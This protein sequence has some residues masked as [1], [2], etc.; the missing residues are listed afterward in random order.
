MYVDQNIE[1]VVEQ[2]G[3]S[4]IFGDKSKDDFE[5]SKHT[6]KILELTEESL[7]DASYHTDEAINTKPAS[8]SQE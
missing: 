7:W 8:S 5:T 2:C 4:Y 3:G 6:N 1:N